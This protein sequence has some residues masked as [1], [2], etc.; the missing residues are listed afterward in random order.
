MADC[1]KIIEEISQGR[2]SNKELDDILERLN[3]EKQRR[4]AAGK[5]ETLEQELFEEGVL[6]ARDADIKRRIDKRN[7]LRNI[8]VENHFMEMAERADQAVDDPSLGVEA[9]LVG[10]NS[11]FE[12]SGRS[13]D[14][15]TNAIMRS[16]TGGFIADLNSS[17]LMRAFNN[18]SEDLE[19]EVARVIA[20]LNMPEPTRAVQASSEAK[21]LGEIMFKYQR[22]A[23][24]RENRE[25]SYIQLKAGRVVRSSHNPAKIIKAGREDWKAY[26]RNKLD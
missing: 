6:M 7:A 2:L 16:Y 21:Q 26:I 11:P 4:V 18:M 23:L 25:G 17:G 8:I 19:R 3:A 14:A 22:A 15:I 24:Q 5:L 1:K 9:V 13:I 10:V 20:D 12:G